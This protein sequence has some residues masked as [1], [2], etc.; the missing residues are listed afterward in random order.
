VPAPLP[1]GQR[2]DTVFVGDAAADLYLT[3][4]DD[5]VAVEEGPVSRRLVLPFEAKLTCEVTSR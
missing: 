4:A 2:F 3:V 5:A 1:T